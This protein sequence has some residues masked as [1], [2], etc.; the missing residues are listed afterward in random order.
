MTAR[1]YG[2]QDGSATSAD[3]P[4]SGMRLQMVQIHDAGSS[5]LMLAR[6]ACEECITTD[7]R[8]CGRLHREL[9]ARLPGGCAS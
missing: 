8:G 2:C 5:D 9:M 6:W 7:R 1:C 4:E 3:G